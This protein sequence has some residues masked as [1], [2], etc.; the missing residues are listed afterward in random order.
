M[1]TGNGIIVW[2]ITVQHVCLTNDHL[3]QSKICNGVVPREIGW[4]GIKLTFY[5]AGI[6]MKIMIQEVELWKQEME[7][8]PTNQ[9]SVMLWS[10]ITKPNS[11]VSQLQCT[12]QHV[13][14]LLFSKPTADF[15]VI[16]KP[17]LLA[18]FVLWWWKHARHSTNPTRRTQKP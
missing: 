13:V 10:W 9:R 4:A 17:S 1:E 15:Q 8:C 2:P 16:S 7:F 12:K 11:S 14:Q 18:L 6:K 5:M 3:D